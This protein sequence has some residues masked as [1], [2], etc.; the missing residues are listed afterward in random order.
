MAEHYLEVGH[1]GDVSTI[2]FNLP[3]IVDGPELDSI[4]DELVQCVIAAEPPKIL[5]DFSGV[6]LISSAAIT[7]LRD[8]YRA[9][10]TRQGVLRLCNVRPEIAEVLRFTRIDTLFQ[11]APDRQAALADF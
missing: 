11:I 2:R 8:L 6:M 5:V 1:A 10:A 4:R 7:L 3:R 9:L